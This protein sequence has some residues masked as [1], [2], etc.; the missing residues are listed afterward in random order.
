M[1][2]SLRSRLWLSYAMM[3][4]ANLFIIATVL[5]IY[6][7][8]NPVEYRQ[9]LSQLR[10]V[11]SVLLAEKT[12]LSGLTQDALQS[13]LTRYGGLYNIRIMILDN[14]R[15]I[16][17]DTQQENSSTF[18]VNTIRSF[19]LS[20]IIRDT[21]DQAWL[22]TIKQI[23]PS[24]WLVLA[25]PRP[26]VQILEV[27]RDEMLPPFAIA[28]I[29]ALLLSLLMAYGLTRWIANPLQKMLG[30]VSQFPVNN[31]DNL[32]LEGPREV[33]DLT[34]AF[35]QMA[36]RIQASQKSQRDFVANVS[37]EL[38]TPLT[39][40]QGFSQALLDGTANTPASQEQ[41]ASI[42]FNE[43]E[44]MHRLVF[45]LLDLARL[46]AGTADFQK[47][48]TS[49][50]PL[51]QDVVD[52][53]KHQIE[54][55]N[56]N[57]VFSIPDLPD[58]ICDPDRLSQVF[59]NLIDNAIKFTP[60]EKEISLQGS[61]S[62]IIVEI[63]IKDSG[64]G[65]AKEDLPHIF[66]RFYQS[67]PSRKGGAQHGT[68]LGLAIAY[69]IVQAHNGKIEAYSEEGEGCTFIVQLPIPGAELLSK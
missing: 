56:V 11:E 1:F 69:E 25:V 20:P 37:H 26:K 53:L 34:R 13:K 10:R 18:S 14:Q 21:N 35:N 61:S 48:P 7:I 8:R 57:F 24:R 4:G 19:R 28:G 32:P 41:A 40:I 43:S 55:A 46:D 52:K 31:E 45:N 30:S 16:L 36:H 59:T 54:H 58:V 66:E 51:L 9:T 2:S 49:L 42:I 65:I 39:S 12:N 15:N 63:I 62:N 68:G 60:P 33:K 27:L 64:E 5:I 17:V 23:S 22:V 29:I 6:L 3:I 44:R 47:T 38:K 67:D 50:K